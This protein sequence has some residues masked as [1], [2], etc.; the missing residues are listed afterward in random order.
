[1]TV[2]GTPATPGLLLESATDAPPAPG[3]GE[4]RTDAIGVAPPTTLGHDGD[5]LEHANL[6][7]VRR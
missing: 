5:L 1:M 4:N 7:T 6:W 3:A 2:A